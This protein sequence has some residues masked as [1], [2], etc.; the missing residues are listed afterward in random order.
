MFLLEFGKY[1]SITRDM[2]LENNNSKY[3]GKECRACGSSIRYT[4]SCKCVRCAQ[5][6][7]NRNKYQKNS[8]L[9]SLRDIEALKDEIELKKLEA[10]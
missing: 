4:A 10:E 5:E 7:A 2:A 1:P 6:R 3:H 8:S 9:H